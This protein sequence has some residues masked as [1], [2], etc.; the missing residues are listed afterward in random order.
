MGAR[1]RFAADASLTLNGGRIRRGTLMSDVGGLSKSSVYLT[2]LA[3]VLH[4]GCAPMTPSKEDLDRV[5]ENEGIVLGSVLLTVAKGDAEESGGADLKGRKAGELEYSVDVA[6]T[7]G[8][9]WVEGS[10]SVQAIPGKEEVFIWK[11]PAGNYQMRHLELEVLGV[12]TGLL[13]TYELKKK[14]RTPMAIN[15]YVKPRKTHYIGKL[16]IYLPNRIRV[17]SRVDWEILDAQEETIN[18]LKG[19]HASVVS[20]ADKELG[21]DLDKE[22]PISGFFRL[23]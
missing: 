16:V 15:F 4:A 13:G 1:Q 6:Q 12:A 10:Y 5:G 11:L 18:E 2:T 17:G 23:H 20:N 3:L 8:Q 7:D 22:L 14:I 21:V 19:T 9:R